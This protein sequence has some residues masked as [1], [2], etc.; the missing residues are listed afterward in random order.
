MFSGR[1]RGGGRWQARPSRSLNAA[2]RRLFLRRRFSFVRVMLIGLSVLAA[3]WCVGFVAFVAT[4]PREPQANIAASDAIVVLTGGEAR[5]EEAI[6]LLTQQRGQRLLISGVHPE[7]TREDLLAR[8]GD[9]AEDYA[10][11]V[12]LDRAALD[13]RGNARETASWAASHAYRS[14]IVVTANYHMPRSLLEFRRTMPG[15]ELVPYPVFPQGFHPTADWDWSIA[16]RLLF[17]EYLKYLATFV[18]PVR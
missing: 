13:T 1:S 6:H 12:D 11:C 7:T 16:L 18:V 17:A 9:A 5:V 4:V 8:F 14:L 2:P 3:L 10:C 15:V